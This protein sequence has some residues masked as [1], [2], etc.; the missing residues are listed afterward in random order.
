MPRIAGIFV[1]RCNVLSA[2]GAIY[3]A[4]ARWT[5]GILYTETLDCWDT[6]CQQNGRVVL[7][8]REIINFA[9]LCHQP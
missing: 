9:V 1:S 3:P 2:E 4:L 7:P 5:K 8:L 6:L